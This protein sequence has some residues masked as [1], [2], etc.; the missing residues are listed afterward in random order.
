MAKTKY[1]YG[2][3]T[4]PRGGPLTQAEAR[5]ADEKRAAGVPD[6]QIARMLGC[7]LDVLKRGVVVDEGFAS[8]SDPAALK[9]EE[10]ERWAWIDERRERNRVARG[11]TTWRADKPNPLASEASFPPELRQREPKAKRSR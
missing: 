1:T 10:H 9:R 11:M 6:H 8:A 4:H 2:F 5:F 3:T 7:T